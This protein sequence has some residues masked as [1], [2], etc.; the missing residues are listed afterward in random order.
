[1]LLA[2]ATLSTL[3]HPVLPDLPVWQVPMESPAPQVSAD[4]PVTQEFP[5]PLP[6]APLRAAVSAHLDNVETQEPLV[7]PDS[8]ETREALDPQD[9]VETQDV[10]VPLDLRDLPEPLDALE[11]TDSPEPQEI[12]EPEEE[13][14][15]QEH[16]EPADSLVAQDLLDLQDPTDNPAAQEPR[17]P[18]DPPAHLDVPEPSESPETLDPRVSQETMPTTAH[19]LAAVSFSGW[20]SRT[21]FSVINLEDIVFIWLYCFHL[22]SL[23]HDKSV[24]EFR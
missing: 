10:L 6:L 13:R 7:S 12:A 2:S 15:P 9:S 11:T 14:E 8:P 19:A 20:R 21:N 18:K 23:L 22:E 1:M 3:A 24:F 17:D 5:A 4:L 16:L